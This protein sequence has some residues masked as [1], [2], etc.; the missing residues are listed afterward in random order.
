VEALQDVVVAVTHGVV[1]VPEA[2]E[3]VPHHATVDVIVIV[4]IANIVDANAHV[5]EPV[6]HGYREV[7]LHHHHLDE[8]QVEVRNVDQSASQNHD[9]SRGRSQ[10]RGNL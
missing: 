8:V 3:E 6:H 10:S 2:L 9:P 5:P 7:N 4:E 1:H